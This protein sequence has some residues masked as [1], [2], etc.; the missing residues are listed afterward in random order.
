M[1]LKDTKRGHTY[2]IKIRTLRSLCLKWLI[3]V[4]QLMNLMPA[5]K[6]LVRRNPE[7]QNIP[8]QH[9]EEPIRQKRAKFVLSSFI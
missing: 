9:A 4:F 8:L 5:L 1:R 2:Y 6:D 3:Q 7:L